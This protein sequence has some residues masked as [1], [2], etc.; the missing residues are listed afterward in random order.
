[1]LALTWHS[2]S[3]DICLRLATPT[4]YAVDVVRTSARDG[5]VAVIFCKHLKCLRL[6]V[7]ACR[8]LKKICVRLTTLSGPI[9]IMNIYRR[10]SEKPLFFDEPASVLETLVSYSCPVVVGR[11]FNVHSQDPSDSDTRRLKT[12]LASFDMMQHSRGPTHHYGNMLDLM[13]TFADRVPD[14][15]NIDLCGV[16]SDHA[17]VTCLLPLSRDL[18]SLA[19]CLNSRWR[20]ID[21][22]KLRREIQAS[23][24]CSQPTR[25]SISFSRPTTRCCETLLTDSRRYDPFAVV[26]GVQHHGLT[27]NT[28][29]CVASAVV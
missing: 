3:D 19:K 4:G 13:L 21:R 16:V 28:E 2:G 9:T 24:L 26:Q 1:M 12:L 15:V 6:A 10:G 7:P 29:L 14:T 20:R 22:Q 25:I 17:L 27:L 23:P 8:T 5:G 18:P 11:D